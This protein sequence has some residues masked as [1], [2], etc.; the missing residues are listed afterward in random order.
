MAITTH[1]TIPYSVEDCYVYPYSAGVPGTGKDVVGIRRLEQTLSVETSEHRGDNQILASASSL[2][3]VDIDVEIGALNLDAVVALSGGTV[4]TTGV[5]PNQIRTM[6][7]KT[8]DVVADMQI[9][10]QT[11]SKD[12]AGGAFRL[13]FPRCQWRSGP[14]YGMAD[15]EYPA[16]TI[17]IRAVPNATFVLYRWEQFE[18]AVALV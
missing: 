12:A 16:P 6:E 8:T 4:A 1:G 2:N 15:N 14:D 3:F 5:A 11:T 18:T 13:V 17:G 10:S 7:R 9:K